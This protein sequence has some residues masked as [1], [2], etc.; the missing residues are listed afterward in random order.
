MRG[1]VLIIHFRNNKAYLT[2]SKWLPIEQTNIERPVHFIEGAYWK[3]SVLNYNRENGV[4]FGSI[5]HHGISDSTIPTYPPKLSTEVNGIRRLS[6]KDIP[7]HILLQS[8]FNPS[9]TYAPT[10]NHPELPTS[11]ILASSGTSIPYNE[12]LKTV[13]LHQLAASEIEREIKIT[14]PKA[15]KDINFQLGKVCFKHT[16]AEIKQD[17]EFTIYNETLREEFDAVKNYISNVLDTKKIT[18][19]ATIKVKGLKVIEVTASS[20][21]INKITPELFEKVRYEFITVAIKRRLDEEQ[22]EKVMTMEEFM[23]ALSEREV[24]ATTIYQKEEELIED[25]LKITQTK[26]YKHLRYLSS[27]HDNKV[28]KLR[29]LIKPFS[30]IFLLAGKEQYYLVWETLDTKEATYI[31]H[32]D[33]SLTA[34]KDTFKKVE[35]VIRTIKQQ[36]KKAYLDEL[37]EGFQRIQHVYTEEVNGFIKWKDELE[38]LLV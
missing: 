15:I 31:W 37:E 20:P 27:K 17:V 11:S 21:E 28:M 36:G 6:F 4:L 14:W 38:T 19:S 25:L 8:T 2:E 32:C 9:K 23:E 18:V 16:I 29:F 30:Y 24:T 5:I 3:V 26:H 22:A 35:Q 34:L 1:E 33:K 10:Q 12:W 7:T 13:P